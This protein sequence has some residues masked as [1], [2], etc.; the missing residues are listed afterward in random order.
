LYGAPS[1]RGNL[2]WLSRGGIVLVSLLATLAAWVVMVTLEILVAY[3]PLRFGVEALEPPSWLLRFRVPLFALLALPL[4]GTAVAQSPAS[5]V[6]NLGAA[7]AGLGIAALLFLLAFLAYRRLGGL[8]P[9]AVPV[10]PPAEPAES[11]GYVDPRRGKI[12]SGHVLGVVFFLI[13]TLLYVLGYLFLRPDRTTMPPLGYLMLLLV[14]LS[15]ALP[16]ISFALDRYRVPVL[17]VLV[18]VS[19]LSSQVWNTDHYYRIVREAAPPAP[20]P[21][22]A[23]GAA[24][25]RSAENGPIVVVAASGGGITA[26]LWTARVLTALQEEVGTDFT[27]SVRLISSVSGGSVGTMYFLDRFTPSGHP[28]PG[29]L[30]KIVEAA[31]A[32]SLEATAWGVTYPDLFRVFLGFLPRDKTLDRGWALEQSWKRHLAKP[33]RMLSDWRTGVRQGWLPAAVLNS[34]VVETGE[35]FLLTSL[36][37]PQSWKARRFY[38]AYPGYDVPVVTA[39]RLS[40]TFP[41]VSPITQALQEDGDLPPGPLHLADGGYYDNFGVVTAVNWLRSLVPGHLDELRRRGVLLVVIRA[42]PEKEE[43]TPSASRETAGWLYTTVG[44]ILTM[45]NVRNSTQAF[46]NSVEVEMLGDAWQRAYR[47]KLTPV[48]FELREKAPLSWKL[49]R[50]ETDKILAGWNEDKNRAAATQVKTL[51]EPAPRP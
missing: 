15:W 16:G 2:F 19:F 10:P 39:A 38:D 37:L 7:V 28:A 32:P 22:Q 23:F 43:P 33:D 3:A 41:W 21:G 4:I 45:S 42:F 30:R 24:E 25:R 20:L 48:L 31:G 35:Q 49:T 51:F 8:L 12:G 13:T 50:S 29:D 18:A 46:R 47:V 40:A 17:L 36:D 5:F 27:R 11:R 6:W 14:L 44:P 34:T 26:S 1:L 9:L